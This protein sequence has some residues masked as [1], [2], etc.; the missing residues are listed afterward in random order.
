MSQIL[1]EVADWEGLAL[2]LNIKTRMI[3]EIMTACIGDA[4]CF[5]RKLVLAYCD[6]QVVLQIELV[7]WKIS[8]TLDVTGNRR[9]ADMLRREY[10][11]IGMQLC[12]LRLEMI[13]LHVT[14][15][16]RL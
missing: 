2:G 7:V 14:N 15:I 6:M 12:T 8:K 9:Q 4:L 10:P 1:A 5:R 16:S 3:Y 13:M 11:Q